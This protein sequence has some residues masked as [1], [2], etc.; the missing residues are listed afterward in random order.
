MCHHCE[1][2][3]TKPKNDGELQENVNSLKLGDGDPICTCKSCGVK[4]KQD[5]IKQG[6]M[7]TYVTPMIS[8]T[9]SL[10]SSDRSVS[11][12]SKFSISLLS[13]DLL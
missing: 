1:A 7:S 10:S 13:I 11:S 2:D 6:V 3:L 9:N 4:Q 8:P 12:C 5:S